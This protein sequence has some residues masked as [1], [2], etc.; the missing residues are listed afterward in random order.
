MLQRE[1]L[2]KRQ[3][4]HLI[5]QVVKSSPGFQNEPQAIDVNSPAIPVTV[6]HL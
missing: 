2:L 4:G 1:G 6:S 3:D 5:W